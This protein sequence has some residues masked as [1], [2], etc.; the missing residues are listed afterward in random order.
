MKATRLIAVG[1]AIG[2]CVFALNS[3]GGRPSMEECLEGSDFI[4]NAA[5]SREAGIAE[6]AFLGRMQEDF[7]AIRAFPNELRCIVHDAD[8]EAFLLGS[9]REVFELPEAPEGHRSAFLRACIERMGGTARGA[10]RSGAT[11]RPSRRDG[12]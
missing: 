12:S 11:P 8:D 3:F 4:G 5:L 1:V 2:A 6:D 9:A 10:Q 7:V